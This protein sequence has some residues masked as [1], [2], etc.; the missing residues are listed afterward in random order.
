M[1]LSGMSRRRARLSAALT[2]ARVSLAARAGSGALPSS[3]SVSAGVQVLEGLQRGGE[4]LPQLV[5]QP[6]HLPGPL[7]DQR[8]MGAGHHLDAAPASALSPATARSWWESVRTMS[9]SMCASP[10]SLLAPDTPC[11]SRYR[12]ACSGFTAYTVYPAATSAATH[13]P[14]SVS[15]PIT[16]SAS[17]G[18]LAQLLP[19]QL[20]QP[21]HPGHALRQP[22]LGQHPPGLVHQLHV[23]MVG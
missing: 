14:R 8:L 2:C 12:D 1:A 11:R 18:V 15:I 3:S 10:P 5:P 6:L 21:G 4:V 23:V 9:V 19:D 20:V 22:P 7:P 13:G 17:S 16:T